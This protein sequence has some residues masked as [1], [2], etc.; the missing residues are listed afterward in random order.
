[1]SVQC[2]NLM[3][4]AANNSG[5]NQRLRHGSTLINQDKNLLHLSLTGIIAE[6]FLRNNLLQDRIVIFESVFDGPVPVYMFAFLAELPLISLNS[7]LD[8]LRDRELQFIF[9]S[10]S[11]SLDDYSGSMP[12]VVRNGMF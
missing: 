8:C 2:L 6:Y 1:M 4:N 7:Q 11:H 3:Q 10:L 12:G 9:Q 5:I